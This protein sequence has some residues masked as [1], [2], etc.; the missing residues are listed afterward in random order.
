MAAG[1]ELQLE[2]CSTT[3]P[4]TKHVFAYDTRVMPLKLG[5]R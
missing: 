4:N 2:K 3:S 5:A 1:K